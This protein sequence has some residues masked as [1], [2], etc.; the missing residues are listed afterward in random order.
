MPMIYFYFEAWEFKHR[1]SIIRIFRF[2]I[3]KRD[4]EFS[5]HGEVRKIPFLGF[6]DV[7]Y[8]IVLVWSTDVTCPGFYH[9]KAFL[10][11]RPGICRNIAN[12]R[13]DIKIR[14]NERSIWIRWIRVSWWTF[15]WF[16]YSFIHRVV[17]GLIL[18]LK[19]NVAYALMI[20]VLIYLYKADHIAMGE[21]IW[22]Y[23]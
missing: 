21:K 11:S 7:W 15:R 17:S 12:I 5:V 22:S 14:E 19:R 6:E 13:D 18:N 8:D 3:I 4:Q 10:W 2:E 23:E 1:D 20:E 16:S 9:Q